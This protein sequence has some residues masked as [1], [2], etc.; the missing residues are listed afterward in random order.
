MDVMDDNVLD[1]EAGPVL[2]TDGHAHF[3][4]RDIACVERDSALFF[5]LSENKA[6][7]RSTPGNKALPGRG[8]DDKIQREMGGERLTLQDPN[9]KPLK[10]LVRRTTLHMLTLQDPIADF[11]SPRQDPHAGATDLHANP[12]VRA[13]IR[14]T[15]MMYSREDPRTGPAR[16]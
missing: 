14:K 2:S 16:H 13:L 15:G 6:L 8:L 9:E 11:E 7:S 10:T 5:A 12:V 4:G 1:E 3:V